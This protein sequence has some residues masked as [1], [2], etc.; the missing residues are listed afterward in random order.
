MSSGSVTTSLVWLVNYVIWFCDN[1]T[2]LACELCHYVIWFC[3][4]VTSLVWKLCHYV[5]C[6]A[7]VSLVWIVNYENKL[8]GIVT[9]SL[10]GFVNYITSLAL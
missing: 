2:S 6:S 9:T 8:S 4:N 5:I 1:I 3:N 10:D 7:I